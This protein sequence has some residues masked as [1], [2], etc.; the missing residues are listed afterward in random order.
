MSAAEK[1]KDEEIKAAAKPAVYFFEEADSPSHMD[2]GEGNWLISY[3]DMMTLLVGFFVMLLSFSKIDAEVFEK[4]KQETSKI[5]GGE[6]QIP[7][8]EL[9]KSLDKAISE[10]GLENQVIVEKSATGVNI[11]FRGALFFD[12]ASVAM[13]PEALDLLLKL[14]PIISSKAKEYELLIEGH[15]DDSPINAGVIASNWELS[16]LRASSVLRFF[17][18]KGFDPQ[19]LKAIGMADTR[20]ILPNRDNQ[21]KP[22]TDNQSQNRRVVIKIIPNF[23]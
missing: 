23:D 21:G 11:T 14:Q 9:S 16:S 8:S 13:K 6:Y 5:F 4:V 19:K 22:I 3:A 18:D 7:F 10:K 20:P 2:E 12:S 1:L 17:L 15:T